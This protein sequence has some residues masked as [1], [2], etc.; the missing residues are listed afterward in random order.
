MGPLPI[1]A[2]PSG[3]TSSQ[4]ETSTITSTS[5]WMS[6]A[7]HRSTPDSSK[8]VRRVMMNPKRPDGSDQKAAHGILLLLQQSVH[9][10]KG[11]LS[12]LQGAL[13]YRGV[14]RLPEEQRQRRVVACS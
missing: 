3:I 13:G 12:G 5:L 9:R 8:D 4:A 7:G 2:E 10:A 1:T 14:L 6:S 11:D